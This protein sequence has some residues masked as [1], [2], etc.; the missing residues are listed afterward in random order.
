MA[1]QWQELHGLRAE[2]AHLR[3]IVTEWTGAAGKD[4]DR[5]EFSLRV[6]TRLV[7]QHIRK[8]E[9]HIRL[10]QTNGE[11]MRELVVQLIE[12]EKQNGRRVASG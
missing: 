9:Q 10:E 5:H 7:G 2:V 1:Q 8:L 6:L 12:E 3:R 4:L 11:R